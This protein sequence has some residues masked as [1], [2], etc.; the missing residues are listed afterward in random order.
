MTKTNNYAFVMEEFDADGEGDQEYMVLEV[1]LFAFVDHSLESALTIKK[2]KGKLLLVDD[3]SKTP[4][5]TTEDK[6]PALESPNSESIELSS[7]IIKDIKKAAKMLGD[8][9]IPTWRSHVF[10]GE[11][12]VIGCDGFVALSVPCDIEQRIIF[13]KEHT[14][15]RM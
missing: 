6:F 12:M 9:E 4:C 3:N 7:G 14:M 15:I 1:D 8:E 11:K 5:S 10:V 13:R 2:E